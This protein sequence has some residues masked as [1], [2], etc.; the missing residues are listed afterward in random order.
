MNAT[1]SAESYQT[2]WFRLSALRNF[3]H[4][5]ARWIGLIPRLGGSSG[6]TPLGEPFF[7]HRKPD[8]LVFASK[9]V[10]LSFAS[11]CLR[12]YVRL[13][14]SVLLVCYLSFSC[15]FIEVVAFQTHLIRFNHYPILS[16]NSIVW[17]RGQNGDP[18]IQIECTSGAHAAGKM[19]HG[20]SLQ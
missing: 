9:C 8:L 2:T 16:Y 14:A 19:K 15:S 7:P 1:D 10:E 18:A 6:K 5:L 12:S 17:D 13:T 3:F 4:S 11:I 20:F